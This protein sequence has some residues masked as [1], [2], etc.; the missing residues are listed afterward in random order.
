[1]VE[2][3]SAR[4]ACYLHLREAEPCIADCLTALSIETRFETVEE[5]LLFRKKLFMRLGMAHS[6]NTEHNTALEKFHYVLQLDKNDD[7]VWLNPKGNEFYQRGD[8]GSAINPSALA[9]RPWQ[10]DDGYIDHL[11]K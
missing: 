7:P 10:S 9:P 5:R 8:I 11:P 2:T 4:A 1:M 3:L 6:L